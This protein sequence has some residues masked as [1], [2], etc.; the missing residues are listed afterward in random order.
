LVALQPD[1]IL[2]PRTRTIPIVLAIV[3]DPN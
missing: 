3:S 2:A 1:V